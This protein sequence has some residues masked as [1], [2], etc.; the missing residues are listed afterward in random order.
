MARAFLHHREQDLTLPGLG[1]GVKLSDIKRLLRT[2]PEDDLWVDA[3]L[4][5]V[6]GHLKPKLR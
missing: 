5:S 3:Q 1:S 2:Q 6:L 4:E